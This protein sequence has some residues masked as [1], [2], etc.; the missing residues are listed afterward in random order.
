MRLLQHITHTDLIGIDTA[1]KES[2]AGA[3]RK[4]ARRYRCLDG[5]ARARRRRR[6]DARG[7]RV[8]ALCQPIYLVVEQ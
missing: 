6:A 1:C 3:Q 5:A 4:L 2:G 8:L 7:R